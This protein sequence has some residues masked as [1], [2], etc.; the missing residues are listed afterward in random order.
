M[1]L[2]E[3]EPAQADLCLYHIGVMHEMAG[4]FQTADEVYG[5]V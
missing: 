2:A 3:D 1:Q 4:N 5:E